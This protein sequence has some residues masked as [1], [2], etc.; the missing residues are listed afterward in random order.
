ML[1]HCHASPGIGNGRPYVTAPASSVK[2][3]VTQR[4][5][6]GQD[7]RLGPAL[8]ALSESSASLLGMAK[9]RVGGQGASSGAG[10]ALATGIR[11]M[12]CTACGHAPVLLV[13][14]PAGGAS[15]YAVEAAHVQGWRVEAIPA[16]ARG[17]QQPALLVLAVHAWDGKRVDS[18]TSVG[19]IPL[20]PWPA[21]VP[22]PSHW[23]TPWSS[24]EQQHGL[25]SASLQQQGGAGRERAGV[26]QQG[27]LRSQS[28][29]AAPRSPG[30]SAAAALQAL[31]R[32]QQAEQEQAAVRA[33]VARHASRIASQQSMAGHAAPHTPARG[34]VGPGGLLEAMGE[35]LPAAAPR[36]QM[37]QGPH[38]GQ[39]GS[40]WPFRGVYK[41]P[42]GPVT[43]T[44]DIAG[45]SVKAARPAPSAGSGLV[46]AAITGP[47]LPI[48]DRAPL[49]A[50]SRG[51][52]ATIFIGQPSM[53][54]KGTESMLAL[55]AAGAP[56]PAQ[57][58]AAVMA[59]S[60][61]E[62]GG[63][64]NTDA[65]MSSTSTTSGTLSTPVTYASGPSGAGV[66]AMLPL[67]GIPTGWGMV[68]ARRRDGLEGAGVGSF[69]SQ[70]GH[71]A[72]G[73]PA[74]ASGNLGPDSADAPAF[75]T[76]AV[77]GDEAGAGAGRPMT[78]GRGLVYGADWTANRLGGD[79][80]WNLL[81]SGGTGPVGSPGG[82]GRVPRGLSGSANSRL[83][84]VRARDSAQQL[85]LA[86]QWKPR[87]PVGFVQMS[88]RD[89]QGLG[90][91][92]A[93]L[94]PSH[95][96]HGEHAGSLHV[97][98][99]G[100]GL[101]SSGSPPVEGAPREPLHA[102]GTAYAGAFNAAGHDIARARAGLAD[103]FNAAAVASLRAGA[104]AEREDGKAIE[105][106]DEQ[107]ARSDSEEVEPEQPYAPGLP[108]AALVFADSLPAQYKARPT[109]AG[110]EV[111]Y[112]GGVDKTALPPSPGGPIARPAAVPISRTVV[113]TAVVS[114]LPPAPPAAP[115]LS[116]HTLPTTGSQ[117]VIAATAAGTAA[118]ISTQAG[119]SS[120]GGVMQGLSAPPRKQLKARAQGGQ[121]GG[122]GLPEYAGRGLSVHVETGPSAAL[123]SLGA[124]AS[125][126]IAYVTAVP[127]PTTS[128]SMPVPS[129][130]AVPVAVSTA[131]PAPVA[132]LLPPAAVSVAL[133][134][135]AEPSH[136]RPPAINGSSAP[137]PPPAPPSGSQ[138]HAPKMR[139]VAPT[140]G[141]SSNAMLA[142]TPAPGG[143]P[144]VRTLAAVPVAAEAVSEQSGSVVST[145]AHR[146][147]AV[148]NPPSSSAPAS[149]ASSG[150]AFLRM[151]GSPLP[152]SKVRVAAKAGSVSVGIPV[153]KSD[154][155]PL[156]ME[157]ER[158]EKEAHHVLPPALVLAAAQY[159]SGPSAGVAALPAPSAS[160]AAAHQEDLSGPAEM[161]EEAVTASAP[162]P[163]PSVE[164][165]EVDTW[166][167]AGQ[168]HREGAD[169][170]ML[171]MATMDSIASAPPAPP[172]SVTEGSSLF[173]PVPPAPPS[174]SSIRPL[175]RMLPTIS[176]PLPGTSKPAEQVGAPGTA[177]PA[178]PVKRA[179]GP[180]LAPRTPTPAGA[181]E[182]PAAVGGQVT[183]TGG[184]A[185]EGGGGEGM[186]DLT[187]IYRS[188]GASSTVR[189]PYSPG[190]APSTTRQAGKQA[191]P[192][193]SSA[194][195]APEMRKVAA[196]GMKGSAPS[197]G[198]K[199]G[200][201]SS[202]GVGLPQVQGGAS[203]L[204]PAHG[205]VR[206]ALGARAGNAGQGQ[207]AAG[208][209]I[210]ASVA[211]AAAA[212]HPRSMQQGTK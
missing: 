77:Q 4:S 138:S 76:P 209:A 197:T 127:P 54:R 52:T 32:A 23:S 114:T 101:G 29:P 22:L 80:R 36:G 46:K 149:S 110:H 147:D 158:A 69:Y 81:A 137:A 58:T 10:Q 111:G 78:L 192:S 201:H 150:S 202:V 119:A 19:S 28:E 79:W 25:N 165:E 61:Q 193:S 53:S 196:S 27:A 100:I 56:A 121:G 86:V 206:T 172:L 200:A 131:A 188:P 34:A 146:L 186:L 171:T 141:V 95:A 178:S 9:S 116:V 135:P 49:R 50:N 21:A 190:E 72:A 180:A 181:R 24:T 174:P 103:A 47:A 51:P 169:L 37:V 14:A 93:D 148:A 60:T 90:A 74:G 15:S 122:G 96:L 62:A 170:S 155:A 45:P 136:S 67:Y 84:G 177:A 39:G 191:P 48:G 5:E 115:T 173:S 11:P 152:V 117:G 75:S 179:A 1:L 143:L 88:E 159:P 153:R 207:L 205:P 134:Q 63:T 106:D 156:R 64:P 195:P 182:H 71:A 162:P 35:G 42:S 68:G 105:Q 40:S 107:A 203:M 89:K 59:D 65:A 55:A 157:R 112:A 175:C 183:P 12:S 140:E 97:D 198:R 92:F 211:A 204:G 6:S 30:T 8:T 142:P 154:R 199:G 151:A 70:Q 13:E 126:A 83:S 184:R 118:A 82:S 73:P 132:P 43:V 109:A 3:S 168:E 208:Q 125:V 98:E 166:G 38:A 164:P 31:R 185:R 160:S 91:P 163:A 167:Q 66:G 57:H 113:P 133:Q 130:D 18:S 144:A 212:A 102:A 16:V 108:V 26:A 161:V 194:G 120:S 44:I 189:G 124:A 7:V 139:K 187:G 145:L 104:G 123:P 20:A 128:V 176:I 210:K 2:M 87:H 99:G 33:V 41:Q 129:A 17:T 94:A 85:G